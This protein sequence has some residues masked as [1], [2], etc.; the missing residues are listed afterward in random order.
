MIINHKCTWTCKNNPK[1]HF[2]CKKTNVKSIVI[3]KNL[4]QCKTKTAAIL[5][6]RC[7]SL[8]NQKPCNSRAQ[9]TGRLLCRPISFYLQDRTLILRIGLT[10]KSS[11]PSCLPCLPAEALTFITSGPMASS[12]QHSATM[13]AEANSQKKKQKVPK[14]EENE[15]K[16]FIIKILKRHLKSNASWRKTS[17][18]TKCTG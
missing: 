4:L 11:S 6:R 2:K 7:S 10:F 17:C 12:H 16:E 15:E 5:N 1:L 13:M 3:P 9:E 14:P 18:T 8:F